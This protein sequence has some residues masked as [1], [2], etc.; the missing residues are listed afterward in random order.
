[1]ESSSQQAQIPLLILCDSGHFGSS[2]S[3]ANTV[4][5]LLLGNALVCIVNLDQ[6]TMPG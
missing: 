5:K 3:Q 1:M 4:S 6:N 2:C